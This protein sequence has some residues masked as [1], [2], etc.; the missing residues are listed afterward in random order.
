MSRS[1]RIALYGIPILFCLA[2]HWRALRTWF[3][4]DDF[5]WLKLPGMIHSP[6]DLLH[7]LFA[8]MAEGTVRTLSERL[9][10]LGF[11]SI[12]NLYSPPY[13]ALV[14]LTM[15]AAI[16]LLIE[17]TRR[18]TGSAIAAFLAAIL[19]TANAGLALALGW[20][21]A[22]NEIAFAFVL[23]LEFRLLLLAIDTSQRRYWIWLWIV[24]ILGFGVL[25][26]NVVFP[27][28]AAAYAWL[29]AR[30]YFRKTLWLFIPSLA[31]AAAHLALIPT[32]TDAYY[33]PHLDA[34]LAKTLARYWAFTLGAYRPDG[35][36]PTWLSLL[37]PILIAAALIVFAVRT[38]RQGNRLPVFLL[39]WFAVVIAA[40]LPF[41]NHVTEY[42]VT[43]PA[44]GVAIVC[45]WALSE[46]RSFALVPATA[47]AAL[48][49]VLSIQDLTVAERYYYNRARQIKYLITALQSLPAA[50]R[51][52]TILLSGVTDDQFWAGFL[53]DPFS[54]IGIRHVYLAPS[55]ENSVDAHPEWG[56]IAP[57]LITP[58]NALSAIT[59]REGIVLRIEGRR[60]VDI[61]GTQRPALADFVA[62]HSQF[63][64]A[65]D[66]AYSPR[67]GPTWFD[68]EGDHR[69]MPKTATLTLAG[70][71]K[72]GQILE[73]TGHCPG[74]LLE[75][76]PLEITFRA[77]GLKIGT[78]TLNE[79]DQHFELRFPLP[80][81]LVSRPQIEIEIELS[82]TY[83]PPGE[84]RDLGL[85]F[86]TFRIK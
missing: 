64:D 75:P 81:A 6:A 70:P 27:V 34:G 68:I 78:A 56:G 1:R 52:K 67:L 69:W 31:F 47:I 4:N 44:L 39:A 41:Q 38:W 49:L 51:S 48:Y 32:P 59:R 30:P 20:N 33:R 54:L 29:C 58:E 86:G 15:F 36:I 74:V 43:A 65:G 11:G 84:R 53:D 10:F 8:P 55:S 18:L 25:E 14:F 12:F 13:R 45:G 80:D 22:Y 24:F 76:G 17:I 72:P 62:Q 3:H 26:L 40:V 7:V 16:V 71:Q 60:L 66:P 28:L 37:A 82:R 5:T 42:Y 57:Y 35:W 77:D 79:P 19:W 85:I 21:S 2:V 83:R 63:I 61:T 73:V 46:L 9:F 50:D 23:L